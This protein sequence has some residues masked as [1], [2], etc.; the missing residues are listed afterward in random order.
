MVEV[1]MNRPEEGKNENDKTEKIE[2]RYYDY[3]EINYK[4]RKIALRGIDHLCF[5]FEHLRD[6]IPQNWQKE[7]AKDIADSSLT[8]VEY[9]S[10]EL[11]QTLVYWPLD[12]RKLPPPL[13]EY[14][15]WFKDWLN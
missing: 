14:Q 10:P 8:F 4:G 6:R 7:V 12:G 15:D 13:N 2:T 11:R 1:M 3:R 5:Y 9:F